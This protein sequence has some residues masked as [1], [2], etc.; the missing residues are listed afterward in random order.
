VFI[1]ENHKISLKNIFAQESLSAIYSNI[2]KNAQHAFYEI[3][4]NGM[5]GTTDVCFSS[6]TGENGNIF[7]VGRIV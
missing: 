6:F 3:M 1:E 4:Q 7:M 2:N 5:G